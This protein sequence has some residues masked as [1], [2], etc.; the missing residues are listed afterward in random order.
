L[1]LSGTEVSDLGLAHLKGLAGL[2][3]LKLS[4]TNITDAGLVHLRG[5][6]YLVYLEVCET[7]VTPCGAHELEQCLPRLTIRRRYF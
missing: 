7:R 3:S 5:L 1:D 4:K 6:T 2:T